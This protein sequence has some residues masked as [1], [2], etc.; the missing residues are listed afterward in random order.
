MA[1]SARLH[2]CLAVAQLD[3]GMLCCDRMRGELPQRGARVRG[4]GRGL[5]AVFAVCQT[6]HH[7]LPRATR[8]RWHLR[9]GARRTLSAVLRSERLPHTHG[10]AAAAVRR[11]QPWG[12]VWAR[13]KPCLQPFWPSCSSSP[14]HKLKH[15]AWATASCATLQTGSGCV[16]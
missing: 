2:A 11:W 4:G 9:S 12:A 6:T 8:E 14:P 7:A 16:V 5:L 15:P 10:P 3:R 13:L 1:R